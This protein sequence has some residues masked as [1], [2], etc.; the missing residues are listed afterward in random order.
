VPASKARTFIGE[1]LDAL[2]VDDV[3][4]GPILICPFNR[5][6]FNAPFFRVP[7]RSEGV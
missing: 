1:T 2:S 7:G 3:G 4:Q 6:M 5:G